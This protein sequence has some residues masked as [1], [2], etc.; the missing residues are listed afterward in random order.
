MAKFGFS[1]LNQNLNPNINNGFNVQQ[2]LNQANLINAVRVLSI[3]LDENHP[4]FVELGEWNALGT[5]EYESVTL[6][7]YLHLH[8]LQQNH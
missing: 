3:V 2:A 7:H 1:S 5:I 4:R 8:Y 6:T